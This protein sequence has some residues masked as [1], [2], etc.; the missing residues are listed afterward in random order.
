MPMYVPDDR[1]ELRGDADQQRQR[2][3]VGHADRPEE[4]AVEDRRQRREH[5]LGDDV[6]AGLLRR[7]VPDGDEDLL[8]LRGHPPP[9]RTPD[10][11]AV[12]RDVEGEHEERE[13]LEQQGE[14]RGHDADHAARDLDVVQL[15]ICSGV[16][17]SRSA[18]VVGSSCSWVCWFTQLDRLLDGRRQGR[19]ELGELLEEQVAEQGA[20]GEHA[21]HDEAAHDA[22]RRPPTHAARGEPQDGRLHGDREEPRQHEDEEEVADRREDAQ[23]EQPQ[24]DDD[25]HADD[26]PAQLARVERHQRHGTRA[27][28]PGG[29]CAPIRRMRPPG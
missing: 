15:P 17:R 12:G 2:Q 1:D 11:R 20:E 19:H 10:P 7:D 22:R 29:V 4:H 27:H 18:I 5:D 23:G 21:D 8:A 16:S 24:R 28:A 25:Q 6:A 13:D 26:G 14:R 9:D 3:P